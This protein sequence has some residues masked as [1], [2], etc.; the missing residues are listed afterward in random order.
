M[1]EQ[2]K[3]AVKKRFNLSSWFGSIQWQWIHR[4]LY[5]LLQS[6]WMLSPIQSKK[7]V[8]FDKKVKQLNLKEEDLV[9]IQKRFKKLV[10]LWLALF[11]LAFAYGIYLA[12]LGAWSAVLSAVVLSIMML[13]QAFRYHFWS[14]QIMQRRLNCTL[15]EWSQK[16][17]PI[18]SS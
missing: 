1:K 14:F 5:R 4:L 17:F 6:R 9:Q 16:T 13:T 12:T 10:G 7:D 3:K 18:K 2:F 11:M 8:S 15:K